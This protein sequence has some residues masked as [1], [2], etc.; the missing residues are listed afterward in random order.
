MQNYNETS[1]DKIKD[2]IEAMSKIHQIEILKVLTKNPLIKINENKSGVYVNLSFL[3][4]DTIH[5][6]CHCIQY[7]KDQEAALNN[8]ETQKDIF[9]NTFFV[10]KDNKDEI[11]LYNRTV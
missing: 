11:V 9:I 10:E 8:I 6:L 1:L 2:Y 3:S 5:E 7:I 4:Q